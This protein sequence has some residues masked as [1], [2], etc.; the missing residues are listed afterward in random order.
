MQWG[1]GMARHYRVLVLYFLLSSYIPT[2]HAV[3]TFKNT[4]LHYKNAEHVE[5]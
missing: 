3:T 4:Y 5:M 2:V 1:T